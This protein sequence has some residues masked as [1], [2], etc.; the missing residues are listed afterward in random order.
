MPS[1]WWPPN[2]GA[3]DRASAE[4]VGTILALGTLLVFAG[5]SI[6]ALGLVTDAAATG[7]QNQL[8]FNAQ[9]LAGEIQT[10]D[11]LVRSS[12]SAGPIGRHVSFPDR[13]GNERYT[14]TV[15]TDSGGDQSVIFRS[16]SQSLSARVLFV[17]ETSVRNSTFS[18]GDVQVIRAD[19][20]TEIVVRPGEGA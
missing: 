1:R 19:G 16:N 12:D 20:A 4:A 8:E 18:G 11:Q 9:R 13:I 17:S 3:D 10:V 15:T 7:Q 6:P 14:I 2:P 5:L